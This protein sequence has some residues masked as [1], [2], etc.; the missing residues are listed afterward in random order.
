MIFYKT[1]KNIRIFTFFYLFLLFI[2]ISVHSQEQKNKKIEYPSYLDPNLK[3]IEIDDSEVV[4]DE[5]DENENPVKLRVGL[6]DGMPKLGFC[7]YFLKEEYLK[8]VGAKIITP[9]Y[10]FGVGSSTSIDLDFPLVTSN[11]Y[12]KVTLGRFFEAANF[13]YWVFNYKEEMDFTEFYTGNHMKFKVFSPDFFLDSIFVTGEYQTNSEFESAQFMSS[14]GL[15]INRSYNPNYILAAPY[16]FIGGPDFHSLSGGI[17]LDY[18]SRAV[19]FNHIGITQNLQAKKAIF[20]LN[21][22]IE[23]R[24]KLYESDYFRASK[25][26]D[27]IYSTFVFS[28]STEIF[29]TTKSFDLTL[30]KYLNFTN[31]QSGIFIDYTFA[32][33]FAFCTG[34]FIRTRANFANGSYHYFEIN[35]GYNSFDSK[36]FFGIALDYAF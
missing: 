15:E 8:G 3:I 34:S 13:N 9:F 16:F 7:T 10:M 21:P 18:K 17:G 24:T 25:S 26:Q 2:G 32:N 36:I 23:P 20:S 5:E 19:F 22:E 4:L 35:G 29:Y 12:Q 28:G 14:L 27:V 33:L 31:I 11:L 30:L 6:I 1:N